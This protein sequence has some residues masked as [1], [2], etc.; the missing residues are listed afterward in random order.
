[1]IVYTVYSNMTVGHCWIEYSVICIQPICILCIINLNII[2]ELRMSFKFQ[3]KKNLR[4]L[5]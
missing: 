4:K 2:I 1:V 3:F 5:N